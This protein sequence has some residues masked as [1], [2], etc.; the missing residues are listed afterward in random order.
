MSIDFDLRLWDAGKA[1]ERWLAWL[2]LSPE[3]R[4]NSEPEE[5]VESVLEI[6]EQ[7]DAPKEWVTGRLAIL[8][9]VFGQVGEP[10]PIKNL[11]TFEPFARFFLVAFA[12]EKVE[13]GKPPSHQLFLHPMYYERLLATV[14]EAAIR[15]LIEPIPFTGESL[16]GMRRLFDPLELADDPSTAKMLADAVVAFW[17]QVEPFFRQAISLD[18]GRGNVVIIEAVNGETDNL[19]LLQRAAKHEEWLRREMA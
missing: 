19:L 12:E 13:G 11:L 7:P 17:K 4:E 18:A 14:N 5:Q 16:I 3:E 9:L 15:H 2:E 10:L 8:D 6:M 1:D